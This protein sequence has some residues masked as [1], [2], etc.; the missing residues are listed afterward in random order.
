MLS[1]D[2]L[3][4]PASVVAVQREMGYLEAM[5]TSRAGRRNHSASARHR[6]SKDAIKNF[7]YLATSTPRSLRLSRIL[8]P[9]RYSM[10]ARTSGVRVPEPRHH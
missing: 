3:D 7:A 4:S 6:G 1:Y 10:R 5:K 2:L 8:T 9:C